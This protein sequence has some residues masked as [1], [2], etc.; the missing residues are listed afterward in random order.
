MF[1]VLANVYYMFV[2]KTG[3]G[4]IYRHGK[5]SFRFVI[6]ALAVEQIL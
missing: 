3:K 1:D 5:T 2:N 6:I 4:K